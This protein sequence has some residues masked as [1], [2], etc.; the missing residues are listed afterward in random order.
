MLVIELKDIHKSFNKKSVL[1]GVNL[2]VKKGES[3]VVIG[4]SGSGKSVLLKHIIGLLKPDK[5]SV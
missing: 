3:L 1:R 4:G 5:G 2:K